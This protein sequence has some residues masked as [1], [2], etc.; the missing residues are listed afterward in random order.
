MPLRVLMLALFLL[1][2]AAPSPALARPSVSGILG[3]DAE[4]CTSH[5]AFRITPEGFSARE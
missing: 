4:S 2:L 3:S 1:A 5:D